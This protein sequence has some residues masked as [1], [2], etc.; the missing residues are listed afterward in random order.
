MAGTPHGWWRQ[1]AVMDAAGATGAFSGDGVTPAVAALEG[2]DCLAVGNMLVSERVAPAMTAAFAAAPDEPLAARLIAGLEAGL[3][4]GGETGTLRSAA[5]L[6][7]ERESFPLVDLR[8]DA[9]G[10]PLAA[11]RALYEEYAPWTRDFVARA[12]DPDG[13]NGRPE[14]PGH[15]PRS[16]TTSA[17]STETS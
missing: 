13:A 3:A 1:L 8:V 5:V 15:R 6:V 16:T 14:D 10:E 7:V 4:A 2:P 9:A 17:P 11:L 12:L